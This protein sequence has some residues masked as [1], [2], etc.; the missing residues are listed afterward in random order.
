MNNFNV[1]FCT[2][3]FLCLS[4]K[5]EDAS[6]E[7]SPLTTY[8]DVDFTGYFKRTTGIVAADA[9][10]SIPMNNGK[11]LWLFGD[12]YIDNYDPLT[13][14]VPCLFQVRNSGLL[15]GI[16]DP[17]SFPVTLLGTGT[18]KSYLE[19]GTNTSYWFWPGAGY[20]Q[21]DTAY[22]F[23]SRIRSTGTSGGFGFE[24]VDSQYVAKI[25][26]SDMT[27]V[28]YIN[29]GMKKKI[30]FTNGVVKSDGFCYVYG[31]RDNGLGRDLMV[32]RYPE[33][34]IYA[35]WE[36]RGNTGW[37]KDIN[38]C[39]K[40][41][42]EFTSSFHIVKVE[43]KYV[44][45]TTQFSAGCDQGKEIYSYTSENPFGPFSNK[46]TVW[47]LNDTLQGHLPFFYLAYAHPEYDNGKKELLITYCINGYGT[48]V[49]SC[50]NNRLDPDVYR[51]RAIRVPYALIGI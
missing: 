1:I 49:A 11:S 33:N 28:F 3:L 31:I 34:N 32:A 51:P 40:I 2:I 14:T 8:K 18:P 26:T 10:V 45:I 41:H 37:A 23:Q 24:E 50:K 19:F 22:I 25:R 27:K 48:C 29:L 46:K 17:E 20:Q 39:V 13:K 6:P 30:S 47:I 12:S 35:D 36:Y 9:A 5:K 43:S 38:A 7:V 16:K 21:G 4:C 15:M 42:S 44:L